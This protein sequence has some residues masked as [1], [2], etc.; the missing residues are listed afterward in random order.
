[1]QQVSEATR[2]DVQAKG[3][4]QQVGNLGQ[5]HPQFRVQFDDQRDDAGTELHAGR[6]QRVGGLQHVAA[7][8]APLTLRA[9]PD[10]DV[11]ATHDRAH[12]GQLFLILRR[13]AGHRDRA[14]AVR[15]RRRDRHR[16]GLVNVRRAPAAA[17]PAVV[18]TGPP[19][20]TAPAT[21]RPVLGKGGR[22][23]ATRSLRRGQLPSQ[24]FVFAPHVFDLPLQVALV[25]LQA[26]DLTL[27]A[28]VLASQLALA[29][30]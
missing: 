11:E 16:V 27:L 19:A 13:H 21:L 8:H 3:R 24:A 7:L 1:M 17:L 23:T 4:S 26:V 2:G 15:T 29:P 28:A 22:L 20:G 9:V 14:A 25:S 5:R 12:R 6:A 18:C 10:L 30:G